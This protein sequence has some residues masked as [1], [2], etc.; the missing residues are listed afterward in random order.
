MARTAII[1]VGLAAIWLTACAPTAPEAL[2]VSTADLDFCRSEVNRYR[3]MLSRAALEQSPLLDQYAAAAAEYDGVRHI[4]HAYS[5]DTR[6]SASLLRFENEIPWWPT[7][8]SGSVRAVI[9]EG[10]AAM[11][12]EGPNGSHYQAMTNAT[13]TQIGCGAYVANSE[14]TVVQ[15]F[16]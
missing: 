14:A 11:W 9:R 8:R 6:P 10:I 12:A 13:V 3:A 4:A 15:A 16:R 7:A 2:I 1:V 5:N